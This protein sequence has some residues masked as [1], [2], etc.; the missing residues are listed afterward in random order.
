[1]PCFPW[2]LPNHFIPFSFNLSSMEFYFSRLPRPPSAPTYTQLFWTTTLSSPSCLTLSITF[3]ST[4][5]ILGY[6]K[7]PVA[8]PSNILAGLFF[9]QLILMTLSSILLSYHLPQFYPL[10]LRTTLTVS[11]LKCQP[12]LS[13]SLCSS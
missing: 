8:Y 12:L 6:F 4:V 11:Y 10:I 2:P 9:S 7:I 1:M 13:Q 3:H 5:T